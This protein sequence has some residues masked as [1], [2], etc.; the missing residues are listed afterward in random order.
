MAQVII[1]KLVD[2]PRNAAFHV[3]IVGD[4]LGDLTDEVIV[5][6]ATSFDP[7]L[8]NDPSLTVEKIIADLVG[9]DAWL[10]YDYAVSDTP[11]W[12]ITGDQYVCADFCEFGGIRDRSAQDGRGK[13]KMSTSGLGAGDRGTFLLKLRKD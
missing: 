3:S 5:D 11:I 8:P 1:A 13:I 10:E 7:A 2:G 4:G 9:F 12:N 6:P